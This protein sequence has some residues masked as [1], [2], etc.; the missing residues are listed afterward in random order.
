MQ[1]STETHHSTTYFIQPTIFSPLQSPH[2][3]IQQ[4]IFPPLLP[5]IN[6]NHFHHP[7]QL[8]N[9]THYPF[10]GPLITNHPQ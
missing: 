5:F 9:H 1:T 8:P 3:I 10:T 7:I 4:Q 2:P 6:L